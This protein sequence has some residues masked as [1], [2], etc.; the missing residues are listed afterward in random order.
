MA[1]LPKIIRDT[2]D[3]VLERLELESFEPEVRERLKIFLDTWVRSDLRR[4]GRY[5]DG[6]LTAREME[7]WLSAGD[8]RRLARLRKRRKLENR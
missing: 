6:E 5:D 7:A 2:I 8:R 3:N 1:K 4:I